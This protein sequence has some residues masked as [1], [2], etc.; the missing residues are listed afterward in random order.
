[1]WMDVD[2]IKARC[3][4]SDFFVRPDERYIVANYMFYICVFMTA[5]IFEYLNLY[6]ES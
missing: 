4:P 1:M 2:G 6:R 3:Y 5:I